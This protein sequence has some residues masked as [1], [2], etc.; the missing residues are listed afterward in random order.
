MR[1]ERK[2]P[3]LGDG[4]ATDGSET[5]ETV[6][7]GDREKVRGSCREEDEG[8]EREDGQRRKKDDL[9][10][11]EDVSTKGRTMNWTTRTRKSFQLSRATRSEGSA[12]TYELL[13]S[14]R[15]TSARP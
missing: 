4:E 1:K 8:E 14:G 10:V 11:E 6:D 2:G 3:G 9:Y 12:K 15:R 7:E 13:L 5:V